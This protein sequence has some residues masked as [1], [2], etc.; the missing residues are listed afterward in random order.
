MGV[1][2][3]ERVAKAIK[4]AVAEYLILNLQNATPG[5]VSVS[6]A[7]MSPDL[8]LANVYFSIYG[9]EKQV[10]ASFKT[11]E[12]QMGAIRYHVGQE[13]RL[14]YTPELRFFI[15]DSLGYADHMN[16]VMQDI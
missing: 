9:D 3:Q 16:R 14:K 8:K 2:R 6:K 4:E 12:R 5:F 1:Q 10:D 15:D 13:V 7:K 11:L